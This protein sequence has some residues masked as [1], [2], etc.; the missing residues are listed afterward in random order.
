M[1]IISEVKEKLIYSTSSL[2]DISGEA[3][4]KDLI[5][6]SALKD[7]PPRTF[8]K[9]SYFALP[10]GN[11]F[12]DKYIPEKFGVIPVFK[13]NLRYPPQYFVD[14][15]NKVSSFNTYNHLGARVSLPHNKINVNKFRE[16]LPKDYDD[17]V[18]MQYLEF[19]FPLGLVEDFILHPSL[20]NHSSSYEYFSHID[21]FMANELKFGG[22]TGPFNN[23]PYSPIMISPLMTAPKKP[24]SRRAVFDASFG[25]FSLNLNTPEKVYV[26]EESEFIFPKL[27][28]FAYLILS[29][30]PGCYLWKRDLSR[31]FLQLPLD[32][33]DYDK[34]ACVW[35][36][37]LF[38]FTSFVWG[39]RHAGLNGQRVSN[40]VS[41]IHNH[42]G[43]SNHLIPFNILNYSD[44][45]AG[46]ELTLENAM[47]SFTALS[48]LLSELGLSESV[49][50]A[51]SPTTT[52][53]YLGV[54]FDSVKMEMRIGSE[55]CLELKSDLIT[56]CR[57]TVATKQE[58]QS[59]LGKLMW[60]SRAV[61]FSWAFICRVI[62]EV[63]NFSTQKQKTTLST[64]IKKEFFMVVSFHEY[65]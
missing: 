52:L 16:Y 11:I 23:S 34:V 43:L 54:E 7:L 38:H 59:I 1:P 56:W 47:L 18:L 57:K 31:F 27:D 12:I 29:L 9:A 24:S 25:D 36:G 33:L 40:A 46:A 15:H 62:S 61:K 65:I 37:L 20:K 63:K 58:I 44:D 45:Y 13:E 35:R 22:V 3:F 17:N 10:D 41:R 26:G 32:P 64:E 4:N 55:K 28:D 48:S 49:D 53:I 42:L 30:G 6:N 2:N 8:L 14:L 39:C 60:V 19:G 21:K 5:D 51:V 50:K